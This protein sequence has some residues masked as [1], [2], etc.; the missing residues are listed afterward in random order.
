MWQFL[1]QYSNVIASLHSPVSLKFVTHEQQLGGDTELTT[2]TAELL[3]TGADDKREGISG[4]SPC[5]T[6]SLRAALTQLITHLCAL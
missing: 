6:R 1:V 5:L 3:L 4:P 2:V